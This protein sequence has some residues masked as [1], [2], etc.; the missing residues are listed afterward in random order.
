MLL[1]LPLLLGCDRCGQLPDTDL[2]Q[3][4]CAPSAPYAH[5]IRKNNRDGER[6]HVEQFTSA[7][8]RG[9]ARA[10]DRTRHS[11]GRRHGLAYHELSRRLLR[12]KPAE[13]R[14]RHAQLDAGLHVHRFRSR[15]ARARE[16]SRQRVDRWRCANDEARVARRPPAPHSC[17]RDRQDRAHSRRRSRSRHARLRAACE[18]RAIARGANARR[19]QSRI[20]RVRTRLGIA[21]SVRRLHA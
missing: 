9:G 2:T 5:P 8:C 10:F 21:A 15:R 3:S 11:R 16:R 17:T 4:V 7:V 14:F 6:E 19:G 13:V 18:C 20:D 12:R 1:G